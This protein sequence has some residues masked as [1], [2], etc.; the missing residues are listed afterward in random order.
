MEDVNKVC[1]VFI[2]DVDETMRGKKQR[3]VS[4]EKLEQITIKINE[5]ETQFDRPSGRLICQ[6]RTRQD[7]TMGIHGNV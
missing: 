3:Y 1:D 7:K 4:I 5:S 6:T 2:D